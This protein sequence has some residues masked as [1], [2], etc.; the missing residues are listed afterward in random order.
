MKKAIHLKTFY[1]DDRVMYAY[2]LDPPMGNGYP[3]YSI[4]KYEYHLV[5]I[6]F[7]PSE[8]GAFCRFWSLTD[9]LFLKDQ[10]SWEPYEK[11]LKNFDPRDGNPSD[12]L[13]AFGY[14]KII[15]QKD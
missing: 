10:I 7:E 15:Q 11:Q 4:H 9:Q 13:K 5:G 2:F 3:R 12:A 8:C 1:E 14:E 6:T